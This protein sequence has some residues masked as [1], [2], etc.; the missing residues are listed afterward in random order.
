MQ[1]QIPGHVREKWKQ[2][3]SFGKDF[4][5]FENGEVWAH[6]A[7]R[8][9]YS[10]LDS[11]DP[12]TVPSEVLN[13]HLSVDDYSLLHLWVSVAG[14]KCSSV[15]IDTSRHLI[16]TL[17]DSLKI[18]TSNFDYAS[19]IEEYILYLNGDQDDGDLSKISWFTFRFGNRHVNG[20]SM[21]SYLIMHPLLKKLFVVGLIWILQIAI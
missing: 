19:E 8:R 5:A 13:I 17:M 15:R 12:A 3:C 2:I 20:S 18:K 16:G 4:R 14:G 21:R 6:R 11:I 9:I 1:L 10:I 7:T